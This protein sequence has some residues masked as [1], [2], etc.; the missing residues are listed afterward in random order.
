MGVSQSLDIAQEIMGDLFFQLDEVDVY[1]DDVG[2]FNESWQAH[3]A[4]LNKVLKHST[5]Y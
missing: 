2:V 4:S 5:K 1:I 3:L